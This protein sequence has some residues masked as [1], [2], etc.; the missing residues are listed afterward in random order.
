MRTNWL[1]R[2]WALSSALTCFGCVQPSDPSATSADIVGGTDSSQKWAVLLAMQ[3]PDQYSYCGG[4]LVAPDL[5]FTAA[6]CVHPAYIG[7]NA[8]ITL[9]VRNQGVDDW[10]ATIHGTGTY[11]P[12][13][14][15]TFDSQG[16][17]SHDAEQGHDVAV[18]RLDKPLDGVD[19]LPVSYAAP[20]DVVGKTSNLYGYSDG[21]ADD[22]KKQQVAVMTVSKVDDYVVWN[23]SSTAQVCRGDSGGPATMMVDGRETLVGIISAKWGGTGACGAMGVV[24]MRIDQHA[25]FL[26]QFL[27]PSTPPV[28]LST[29]PD[30]ALANGNP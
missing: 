22:K 25:P 30:M 10:G 16:V 17:P 27:P 2:A 3:T 26:Q 23:A 4:T 18:V 11:D 20:T 14:V 28:D 6:H 1:L 7:K 24:T 29:T 12:A 19:P 15:L 9:Q 13:L 21:N 8:D 5:V